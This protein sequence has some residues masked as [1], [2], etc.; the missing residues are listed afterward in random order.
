MKVL[1]K[2]SAIYAIAGLMLIMTVLFPR[3]EV[4]AASAT[5]FFETEETNLTVGNTISVYLCVNADVTLG[6]F[7]G[8]ISYSSDL[9]EFV[10]GASCITGGDGTLKV[11]DFGTSSTNTRKYILNFKVI[12]TGILE[13]DLNDSV[14]YEYESGNAMSLS[15]TPF[16]I[17]TNAPETASENASLESLKISPGTL[18]PSFDP[19]VYVYNTEVDEN[20]ESLILSAFAQDLDA[21]ISINGN[22]NL[23]AGSNQVKIEVKAK[24]GNTKEYVITVNKKEKLEE[25]EDNSDL[26]E[27]TDTHK[28]EWRFDATN[29]DGVIQISGQYYFTVAKNTNEVEIPKGYSRND[30]ILNGITIPAYQKDG[31]SKSDYLLLVLTNEAGESALYRYDRI[32]KTIQRYPDEKIVIANTSD[33]SYEIAELKELV[34]DY[35]EDLSQLALI[36]AL[37]IGFSGILLI[38]VVHF[39]VKAKGMQEDD[40][41]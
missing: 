26:N 27:T 28:N 31:E 1:L 25:T 21:K 9:V 37:L 13:F 5:A 23:I 3:K 14:A 22:Q 2:K 35:K 38:G 32:D 20:T 24:A 41:D 12:D 17:K 16:K 10:S 33:E 34:R 11:Y 19:E 39:Y 36:I 6:D 29:K 40:L 18:T 7:E 8:F 15:S 30:F 4:K